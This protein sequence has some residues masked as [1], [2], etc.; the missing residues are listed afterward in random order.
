M[1]APLSRFEVEEIKRIKEL[2]SK[3]LDQA[4]KALEIIEDVAS[5]SSGTL[6][7]L[8]GLR[9]YDDL[10]AVQADFTAFVRAMAP[11]REWMTWVDA[12]KEFDSRYRSGRSSLGAKGSERFVAVLVDEMEKIE[13]QRTYA[14]TIYEWPFAE[15]A[16]REESVWDEFLRVKDDYH[17]TR[18]DYFGSPG[19]ALSAGV[20]EA[21]KH[22]TVVLQETLY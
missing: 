9:N 18:T 16:V 15:D 8:T 12:W 1:G 2:S 3:T 17:I 21:K 4:K 19:T 7:T 6:A 13:G 14:V 20:K 22:G 11:R 10:D 5:L